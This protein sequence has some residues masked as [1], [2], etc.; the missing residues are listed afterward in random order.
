MLASGGP[1]TAQGMAF[2]SRNFVLLWQGQLVSQLGNQAFFIASAYFV[3]DATG[4]STV[5]AGVMMASTLPLVLIGPFGGVVA[6]RWPRRSILIVTDALRGAAMGAL[7]LLILRG[8]D[9]SHHVEAVIAVALINGV[10]AALFTPAF[11]AIIPDVIDIERLPLANSITQF[12]THAT[13]LAGQ[14][15]G[16]LVY[17]WWGAGALFLVDSLSFAYAAVLTSW[18]VI[19]RP[20]APA[21]VAVG[22]ALRAVVAQVRDGVAY[23]RS[24]AALRSILLVFLAVNLLFTPVFALLPLYVRD[25]LGRGPEW[26]GW[27]LA[28]SGLGALA[29]A[30]LAAPVVSRTRATLALAATCVVVIGGGVLTLALAWSVWL[31]AAA[32]IAIGAASSLINV[33]IVTA[34]QSAAPTALRGRVMSLV[35]AVSAAAVPVGLGLG[36]VLGDV[37]RDSLRLVV[38]A[39]GALTLALGAA[40]AALPSA[41]TSFDVPDDAESVSSPT[42]PAPGADAG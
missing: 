20:V 32:F 36:G 26:Y 28:A 41:Q 7:A 25:V 16:G 13:I 38:G 24:R 12:S 30:T 18:I 21:P 4:S 8:T 40:A 6:D 15:A 39:C 33:A 19:R 22:S 29:G 31:S 2:L 17:V 10:L 11:Q 23:L 35:V 3:L 14:A 37:W 9:P 34:F 1:D 27:L 5:V 42:G